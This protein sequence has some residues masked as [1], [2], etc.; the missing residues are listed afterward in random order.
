[1]QGISTTWASTPRSETRQQIPG[2]EEWVNDDFEP[3]GRE[4]L[5]GLKQVAKN[6]NSFSK[7]INSNLG[8]NP[9]MSWI[10]VGWL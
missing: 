5:T 6:P 4:F 2:G 9:I 10:L 7:A 8:F 3:L 1:M